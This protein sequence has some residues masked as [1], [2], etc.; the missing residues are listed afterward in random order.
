M[1]IRIRLSPRIITLA[2]RLL[3][4]GLFVSQLHGVGTSQLPGLLHPGALGSD[5]SNYS[6]A[7]L[8]LN[9][10]HA[11]YGPLLAGDR[12]VPGYPEL[13]PAPLLSP[14]LVAVIWRPLALLPGEVAMTAW[15]AGGLIIVS[16]IV[17]G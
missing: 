11:L 15:W 1:A 9:A 12:A 8:R 10:G 16:L 5:P 13:Y 3:A 14:P 17:F 6:A 2:L 7:G 4:I